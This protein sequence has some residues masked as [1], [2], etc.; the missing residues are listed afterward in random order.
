MSLR[1]WSEAGLN[2]AFGSR[3][4]GRSLRRNIGQLDGSIWIPC[5]QAT[6]YWLPW[7]PLLLS[8]L[9]HWVTFCWKYW[10]RVV[11]PPSCVQFYR[12]R[13]D[14]CE[15]KLQINKAKKS[16]SR[17]GFSSRKLLEVDGTRSRTWSL[18]GVPPVTSGPE[19]YFV[20]TTIRS[21]GAELA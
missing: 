9:E 8:S 3:S 14:F 18:G 15:R 20:G 13:V 17:K 16:Y 2:Q 10:R 21:R 11:Y 7:Y 19:G 5:S 12:S 1:I 4:T 6:S